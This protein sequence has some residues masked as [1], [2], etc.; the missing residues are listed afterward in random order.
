MDERF[1]SISQARADL[2]NIG[3]TK[4]YELVNDKRLELVKLDSRSMITG[5]SISKLKRELLDQV[6]A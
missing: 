5:R 3:R 4:L 6:A 1:F 2:G